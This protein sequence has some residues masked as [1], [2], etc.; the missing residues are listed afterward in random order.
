MRGELYL[1]ATKRKEEGKEVILTNV[2]NPQALGQR[3]ITFFRQ[4]LACLVAPFLEE[5]PAFRAKMPKDVLQR[6][7]SYRKMLSGG[8]IGAYTGKRGRLRETC[9]RARANPRRETNGLAAALLRGTCR[10]ARG[11]WNSRGSCRVYPAP[12]LCSCQGGA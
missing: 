10:F 1:A 4:V 7:A 2:G 11:P 12:R 8:S 6:A 9:C 3:P 5:D